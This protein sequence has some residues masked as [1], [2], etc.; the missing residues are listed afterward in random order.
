MEEQYINRLRDNSV[1]IKLEANSSVGGAIDINSLTQVLNS[2]NQ[3]YKKFLEIELSKNPDVKTQNN[4]KEFEQF[5]IDSELLIVDLDFASF[6]AAISPN[7]LTAKSYHTI[8]NS[9]EVK[10][11]SFNNYKEDVLQF[12]YSDEKF[13]ERITNK[14]TLEERNDIYKPIIDNL[15][16]SSKFKFYHGANKQQLKKVPSQLKGPVIEKLISTVPSKKI[17]LKKEEVMYVMYVTSSD[18]VDLFGKKPKFSRVLATTKL[19]KPIYPYQLNELKYDSSILKF[20]DTLSAIVSFEDDMFFITYPDLNI[21]VWGDDRNEAEEAF[22]FALQS[23]VKNIFFEKD[24][25]L[26]D[27]AIRLKNHFNSILKSNVNQ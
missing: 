11:Q 13:V 27:R 23:F 1:Y 10:K 15:V 12:N 17:E 18:E 8:K 14:Y 19:D 2:L 5:L 6:G 4:K 3:S 24:E 9:L 21:E 7:T 22:N 25:N 16:N 26:T 20:K